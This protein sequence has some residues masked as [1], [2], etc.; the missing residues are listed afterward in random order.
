[1]PF[2]LAVL[3]LFLAAAAC[4]V[5]AWRTRQ[6]RWLVAAGLLAGLGVVLVLLLGA[7][8]STM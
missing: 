5:M 6:R 1:M 3:V 8:L 4:A 7:A 2:S